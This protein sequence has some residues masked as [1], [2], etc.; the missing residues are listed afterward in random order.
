MNGKLCEHYVIKSGKK[1]EL[2]GKDVIG[3]INTS[4][5]GGYGKPKERD[6]KFVLEDVRYGKVSI[7]SAQKIY[8]VKIVKNDLVM[9]Q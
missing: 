5:D 9:S 1:I 2:S 7:K 4:G 6:P 3:L 8:R